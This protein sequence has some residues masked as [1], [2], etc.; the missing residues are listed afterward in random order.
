MPTEL[1][2]VALLDR[3]LRGPASGWTEPDWE[4]LMDLVRA[5]DGWQ[6]GDDAEL[7][8]VLAR[9][10]LMMAL[11]RSGIPGMTASHAQALAD[12]FGSPA[13]VRAAKDE[14]LANA[15]PRL[16]PEAIRRVRDVFVASR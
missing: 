9:H 14:E 2:L 4:Q 1:R 10:A 16:R 12:R 7:R 3:H 6:V 15:V 11:A 13:A 8:A 5:E